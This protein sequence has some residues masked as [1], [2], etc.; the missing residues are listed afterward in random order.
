M[1]IDSYFHIQT[2]LGFRKIEGAWRTSY[3]RPLYSYKSDA[4]IFM[5]LNDYPLQ[6]FWKKN[7]SEFYFKLKNPHPQIDTVLASN[8]FANHITINLNLCEANLFCQF[9]SDDFMYPP[10]DRFYYWSIKDS[11]TNQQISINCSEVI[12]ALFFNHQEL[13]TELLSYRFLNE[14][15]FTNRIISSNKAKLNFAKSFKIN[16]L[17]LKLSYLLHIG[18]LTLHPEWN[19]SLNSI[20]SY[21]FTREHNHYYIP[22]IDPPKIESLELKVYGKRIKE[23][24]HVTRIVEVRNIKFPVKDI[25][26]EVSSY[27]N[28]GKIKWEGIN[29][30]EE[31]VEHKLFLERPIKIINRFQFQPFPSVKLII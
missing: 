25:M 16:F 11:I 22:K 6:D 18:L 30:S 21:F 9:L 13:S 2:H 29:L 26:F 12:R 8:N 15:I 14:M 7:T 24:L 23:I 20:Q 19:K 17:K 10:F 28:K 3:L 4:K 1:E 27:Y 5:Y 31:E